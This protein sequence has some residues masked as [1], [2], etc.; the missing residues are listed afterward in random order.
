[1]RRVRVVRKIEKVEELGDEDILDVCA[2]SGTYLKLPQTKPPSKPPPIPK[3]GALR[4]LPR[5]D[6][7]SDGIETGVNDIVAELAGLSDSRRV[8]RLKRAILGHLEP[9]E[10]FVVSLVQAKMS[11]HCIASVSPFSEEQTMGVLVNLV[12]AGLITVLPDAFK[13]L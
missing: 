7:I 12:S 6:S 11:L 5:L 9:K 1:M 4:S 2:P 3:R 10:E 8:P 13:R